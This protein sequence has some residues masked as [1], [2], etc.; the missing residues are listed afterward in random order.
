M[1]SLQI[2][3]LAMPPESGDRDLE[4]ESAGEAGTGAA[5]AVPPGGD[6]HVQGGLYTLD[7][8]TV[9]PEEITRLPERGELGG[10]E[11]T[12][13]GD[14]FDGKTKIRTPDPGGSLASRVDAFLAAGMDEDEEDL[15]TTATRPIDDDAAAG[16]AS[17][18]A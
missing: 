11:P 6:D 16:A 5:G 17:S 12:F 4:E 15:S 9:D 1:V 18:R 13:G 14:T 8:V 3:R 10:P 7:P 2:R